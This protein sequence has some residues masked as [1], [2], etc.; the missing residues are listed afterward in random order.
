M[1]YIFGY[2]DGN[3]GMETPY[4]TLQEA[5]NAMQSK[6]NC[7]SIGDRKKYLGRGDGQYFCVF[8]GTPDCDDWI[9]VCDIHDEI[10]EDDSEDLRRD[11]R[12]DA[13]AWGN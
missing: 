4:D 7:L 8:R 2:Y 3:T 12:L 5:L 13:A 11:I 10:D 1:K 9:E 6:W